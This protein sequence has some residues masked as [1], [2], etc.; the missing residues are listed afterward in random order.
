MGHIRRQA[1]LSSVV[2]YVGFL[3]GF[4]N[5]WYFTRNGLFTPSE[6][7][8]TRL[9]FD[10][11]QTIMAF[12][13]M[14][15]L[16]V[17]YKFHPYYKEYVPA[18]E[19][20][21]LTWSLLAAVGGFIL[22]VFAGW[23]F[24]PLIVR[25][26]SERS[27]L[28]VDYYYWIFPFGLGLLFFTILE[29]FSGTLRKTIFPNF[30]RETGLRLI[31]FVL[32]LIF[33]FKL[34]SFDTFVK[35]FAFLYIAIAIIL[36]LTL[37]RNHEFHLS[38]KVSIVTKK[39]KKKMLTLSSYIYA[40]QIIYI[41]AQVMDSIFIA[42][43]KGLELTGVFALSSYI[44][45]LVQVPQRSII[46]IALPTLA[47]AWK[48]KNLPEISRIYNRTSINL[49]LAALFIFFGIWLNIKDAFI[50]LNI[51]NEYEAGFS[52]VLLLSISRIIDAGTGVNGQIIGTST[53]WRFEFLTGVILLAIIFP[54]NY[55]LIKEFG[56]IG[57]A[58]SNLISF[59]VYNAIRL[60]FLWY[61]FKLQPFTMKTIYSLVFAIGTYFLSYYLFKDVTGWTGIF[62]RSS[63]F[64]SV[65]IAGVFVLKLTPD[66]M[67]LVD[68]AKKKFGR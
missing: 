18:K 61:K 33:Y 42:S 65:F 36:L 51:R 6:Y 12:A 57:S 20:D 50:L 13:N 2:I 31:T 28:F 25:K 37:I 23:M 46:S 67:Q 63:L 45:N 3:V 56:I 48:D 8:L 44:A 60:W 41:L 35:L 34:I 47:Q 27:L 64:A 54:L 53:Q 15:V 59:T 24:E 9:F 58:Y 11:G 55:Y 30:L 62:L 21:M 22:V 32:I 40:G 7:A 1:I 4:V 66:A 17:I 10:V 68:T 26:F 5:T 49:L 19:S 43:L 38:F 29:T 39:F 14:G 52:V 16:S